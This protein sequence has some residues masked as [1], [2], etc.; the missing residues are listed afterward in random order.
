MLRLKDFINFGEIGI[1]KI[2]NVVLMIEFILFLFKENFFFMKLF[3]IL[4]KDVCK[5]WMFCN[6][7]MIVLYLKCVVLLS[8]LCLYLLYLNY[9][10]KVWD[11]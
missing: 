2:N 3:C 9:N 6:K 1:V 5:R 4:E 10:F 7:D 11:L 8:C